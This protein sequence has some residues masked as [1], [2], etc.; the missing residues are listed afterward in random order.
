L[1]RPDSPLIKAPIQAGDNRIPPARESSI[2]TG[3]DMPNARSGGRGP[4]RL[5]W[6]FLAGL[7]ACA[8]LWAA[9]FHVVGIVP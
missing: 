2:K 5:N 1:G 3:N 4:A 7:A 9:V 6:L 8:A